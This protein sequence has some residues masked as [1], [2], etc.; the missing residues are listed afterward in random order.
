MQQ[1]SL[2]CGAIAQLGE[3]IVRNDEVVGSIPTSSTI[4]TVIFSIGYKAVIGIVPF[5]YRR[6]TEFGFSL[7]FLPVVMGLFV[8]TRH[9]ADCP[10]RKD[11][12]WRRCRC[13]KWIRGTLNRKTFRG[14]AQTRS[15]ERAE[16]TLRQ[17]EN[18][19]SPEGP[20]ADRKVTI[21]EA[22]E[23]FL[24]DE[25][26]RHLSKT[27][28]GQSKTLLERQ[29]LVWAKQQGLHFLNELTVPA[30]SKFRA[31]WT[32]TGNNAN[33]A[34][35]KHQRLSGFLWFCVRNEWLERNPARMLK[36]IRV[37]QIPTDY[38][39]REEFRR[40]VDATYAYGEWQGGPSCET[41]PMGRR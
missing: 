14:S 12:F 40:I 17:M 15:W 1:P 7:T 21:K 29:L 13:P 36:A 16:A 38:F 25:R 33:T 10:N 31:T 30:L 2:H 11:R 3:R 9:T 5:L 27:T 18:T 6:L 24:E 39:T 20:K 35:R 4:L 19:A 37:K 26:S 32:S 8:Y 41:Q 28:T 23:A 22:V 34:R